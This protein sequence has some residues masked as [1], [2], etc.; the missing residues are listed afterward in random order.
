MSASTLK[1]NHG[2]THASLFEF[3]N[4][5]RLDGMFLARLK[6]DDAARHEQLLAYRRGNHGFT[7]LQ[8]SELLLACGPVLEEFIGELFGIQDAMHL[9]HDATLAHGPV[10]EFKK[11]FVQRRARKRRLKKEEIEDFAELDAWLARALKQA[12]LEMPDRELAVAHYAQTLLANIDG[13]AAEI[14]QLTRWCIRALTAPAGKTAVHGWPSF[15]LPVPTDHDNLVPLVRMDK[16]PAKRESVDDLFIHSTSLM[17]V[18]KR[19]NLR[20]KVETDEPGYES[21]LVA[22][23]RALT[24]ER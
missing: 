20:A 6:T 24:K 19:G 15:K 9:T 18:D 13:N 7:T 10:F 5:Q 14:E 12:G 17:I 22:I 21:K 4:L 11:Q 23:V 16:D 8:I 2:F 3:E 1:L